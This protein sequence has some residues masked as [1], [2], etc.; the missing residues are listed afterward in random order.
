MFGAVLDLFD[1]FLIAFV[2]PFIDDE[3]QLTFGEATIVLL[4]AGVGAIGGALLWG[5]LGDRY[6]RRRPLIAGILTFS[7]ATGLL[8]AAPDDGWWYLALLR[9]VVGAGV[10]GVAVIAVPLTL[11]FTPTRL[12]T[13]LTGFVTT[14]M[15]PV[16]IA[17]AS[18][19]AATLADPLGW[20]PLFAVGVVPAVLALFVRF[21]V[22]ESPRWL[23]DQ[24]RPEEARASIAYL[25]MKDEDEI[26][27]DAPAPR[28]ET[29]HGD[30]KSTR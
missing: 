25:L 3:W 1:F 10:A 20:R 18:I 2:L 29:Q 24:G 22:P 19:A 5:K 12:R 30:R 6:G 28:A 16:G 11:E 7:I 23:L 17:A 8:A 14:A 9:L 15:V 27:L 26:P 21:Y 13:T 4:S